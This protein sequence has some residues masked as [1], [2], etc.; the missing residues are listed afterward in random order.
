MC[1]NMKKISIVI[2]SLLLCIAVCGCDRSA[3]SDNDIDTVATTQ[4]TEQPTT[5]EIVTTTTA[6]VTE[7]PTAII[8]TTAEPV[9]EIEDDNRVSFGDYSLILPE[10]WTYVQKDG[11]YSFYEKTIYEET[12]SGNL[13][14]IK[15]YENE[16]DI[17][18][19][20]VY[21]IGEHNGYYYY[22]GGPTSPDTDTSNERLLNLWMTAYNQ[23]DDVMATLEWND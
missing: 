8:E 17:E 14:V 18:V 5:E 10:N 6:V 22:R 20:G 15:K 19:A 1:D 12:Q 23:I 7:E 16:R 4:S 3:V 2:C 9:S 21:L 11:Y 13:F